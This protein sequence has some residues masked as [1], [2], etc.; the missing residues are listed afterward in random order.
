ML[1]FEVYRSYR[2]LLA[3]TRAGE[4]AGFSAMF[5][6]DHL[7][8]VDGQTGVSV[9]EAWTSLAGLARETSRIH[10][11]TLVSPAT[12]RNPGVLARTVA[13]VHEMSD[14]RA[15]VGLGA[16][17][18]EP[19]HEGFGLP[20][21]PWPERFDMLEEQLQIVRGL[22]TGDHVSFHGRHY[23][24]EAGLGEFRAGGAAPPLL[25]GGNGRPRTIRLA[26]QFAD[27]LNLDQILDPEACRAAY[28]VLTTELATAGRPADAVTRSNVM[29]WPDD[30]G[31]A[32]DQFRAMEA[33]GVQRL[34]I[35]RTPAVPLPRLA[36][37]AHRFIA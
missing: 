28:G 24:V 18:Y 35:K 26:A 4:D 8:S 37:F 7:L 14:G 5:R 32:A 2:D 3:S 15:E 22:L 27:E 11:G 21:P 23:D 30:F 20:L 1:G 10:L 16:G 13:T 29:P 17:W 31:A 12:F 19:E 34:Y 6:G 25:V 36:E 9:T 33:A